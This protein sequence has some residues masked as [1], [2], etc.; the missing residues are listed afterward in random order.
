[1]QIIYLSE[2]MFPNCTTIPLKL[3]V[4]AVLSLCY[5]KNSLRAK[6]SEIHVHSFKISFLCFIYLLCFVVINFC[7]AK[8]QTGRDFVVCFWGGALDYLSLIEWFLLFYGFNWMQIGFFLLFYNFFLILICIPTVD[9]YRGSF[10]HWN[11]A[12]FCLV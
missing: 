6:K 9:L 5:L 4:V 3:V 11:V 2:N 8:K 12:I 1:M 7:L 10:Q